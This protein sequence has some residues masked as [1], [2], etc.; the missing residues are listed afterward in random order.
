MKC[1]AEERG[2]LGHQSFGDLYCTTTFFQFD[3]ILKLKLDENH[4]PVID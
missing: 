1:I 2:S 3:A 4:M